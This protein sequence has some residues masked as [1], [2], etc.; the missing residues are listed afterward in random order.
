MGQLG[1]LFLVMALIV[2]LG[3]AFISLF[4]SRKRSPSRWDSASIGMALVFGLTTLAVVIL[5]IAMLTHDFSIEYVA[6]YSNL[7]LPTAYLFTALWAG[8]AGFVLLWVWLL[9]GFGLLLLTRWRDTGTELRPTTAA[10]LLAV[11]SFFLIL[12]IFVDSPFTS[13][14]TPPEDGQGM[15]V[16]LQT[17]AMIIHPPALLIGYVAFAIPFALGIAALYT[18][19]LDE[20][21]L[22]K[23]RGWAVFAWLFLGLGNLIG[24]WWAY[25]DLGFGGYWAWDPVEN[26]SLMPWLVGTAFLHSMHIQRRR[27]SFRIWTMALAVLTF[28]LIILGA[29]LTRTDLSQ[30]HGFG[31]L[32]TP[33]FVVMLLLI[34]VGGFGLLYSRLGD[35]KSDNEIESVVSRE[36]AF[37]LNNVLLVGS[38]LAIMVGTLAPLFI[39]APDGARGEVSKAYFNSVNAPIFLAVVLLA[40]ICVTLGWR[41]GML[42]NTGKAMLIS[43]AVAVIALVIMVVTGVLVVAAVAFALAAFLVTATVFQWVSEL[44][45]RG[46]GQP[47]APARGIW[48]FMALNKNRYGAYIVHLS[49]AVMA[50]GIIGSSF[51]D[52]REIASL[53]PG[54]SVEIGDYTLTFQGAEF[55]STED[56]MVV[57]STVDVSRGGVFLSTVTPRWLIHSADDQSIRV[58]IRSTLAEDLYVIPGL[59]L[60]DLHADWDPATSPMPFEVLLNPLVVWIWIGS[61]MFGLG[62]FICVWPQAERGALAVKAEPV[63]KPST[64]QPQPQAGPTAPPQQ[65]GR[66]GAP[67]PLTRK[68]A[69]KAARR[70]GKR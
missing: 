34:F 40:G 14:P 33:Y 56:K 22:I 47:D 35:L 36:S 51:F 44:A 46:A 27:K 38:M 45:G 7:A 54:Q 30:A 16:A 53:T 15:R 17:P 52:Q 1:Y 60:S 39:K 10:V 58:G 32:G 62:G 65:T 41:K 23:A 4:S 49:L 70:R 61:F 20:A 66:P 13:L 50:A 29:F 24:A 25:A 12:L 59:E 43:L 57:Q 9:S 64:P 3:G 69:K 63:R 18:R 68:A 5:E 8:N 55:T 26:S 6:R 42:K 11:A 28:F 21:W 2:A 48:G 19:R 67:A 37:L 31:N